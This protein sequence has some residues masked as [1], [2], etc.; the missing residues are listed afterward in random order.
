M[1]KDKVE[2]ESQPF[3]LH[4]CIEDSIELRASEMRS[5]KGLELTC[6]FDRRGGY[7]RDN[8]RRSDKAAPGFG[9]PV[10]QC[11]QVHRQRRG[12]GFVS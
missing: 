4:R 12:A 10:G 2:L 8:H 9:K 7:S 1:D 11:H 5:E 3:E 6:T